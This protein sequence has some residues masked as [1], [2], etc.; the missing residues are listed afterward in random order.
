[1]AVT[2]YIG[3]RYVPLFAEPL[4]WD[5]TKVYEP[6]TIVLYAG[7]SY[8]SRQSVPAGID[9]NNTSYWALTGNYNAQIEQ[10]RKEVAQYGEAV[11]QNSKDIAAEILRATDVENTLSTKIDT[12]ESELAQNISD[13]ADKITEGYKAADKEIEEMVADESTLLKNEIADRKNA[14]NVLNTQIKGMKDTHGGTIEVMPYGAYINNNE[15]KH[16]NNGST[17]LGVCT[18]SFCYVDGSFIIA[19]LHFTDNSPDDTKP[20]FYRA[21]VNNNNVTVVDGK[22]FTSHLNS[23]CFVDGYYYTP[24]SNN[25]N[26]LKL[27]SA[28]NVV[29]TINCGVWLSS[30]AYDYDNNKF[31][32]RTHTNEEA[33]I[34]EFDNNF[35]IV[36]TH[37]LKKFL[38][39]GQGSKIK[40]GIFYAV[41]ALGIT[42]INMTN[43]TICGTWR[44]NINIE[45]EDIEFVDDNMYILLQECGFA[46][47]K[48]LGGLNN[49]FSKDASGERLFAPLTDN[50]YMRQ[51]GSDWLEN[52][53]IDYPM[54]GYLSFKGYS[55]IYPMA[56]WQLKSDYSLP[57][58]YNKNIQIFSAATTTPKLYMTSLRHSNIYMNKIAFYFG[59]AFRNNY[60]YFNAPADGTI[61]SWKTDSL[62]EVGYSCVMIAGTNQQ[63]LFKNCSNFTHMKFINGS[64]YSHGV[65]LIEDGT[66]SENTLNIKSYYNNSNFLIHEHTDF[67]VQ[68]KNSSSEACI[69]CGISPQHNNTIIGTGVANDG[70]TQAYV[71]LTRNTSTN[72]W[73]IAVCK[74][75]TSSANVLSCVGINY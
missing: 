45:I 68:I 12:V 63:D 29:Q 67:I 71:K 49:I 24:T 65:A 6:L 59:N 56:T 61:Q 69:R 42:A 4:N 46:I 28:F 35:K 34:Y 30:L 60:I 40:D 26:I 58:I 13:T 23:I 19:G 38:G 44:I 20:I 3:A 53:T 22:S 70:A 75:G 74:I 21:N 72:T 2:Q 66:Y 57:G 25:N 9:I 37:N 73:N 43:W 55:E 64:V 54:H 33:I 52:G 11:T 16:N 48:S 15:L 8:T 14:D 7:N 50:I 18:E 51:S 31:Y 10:Y 47:A 17:T 39:V 1:M 5:S 36:A 41:T 27:D 62:L 32:G